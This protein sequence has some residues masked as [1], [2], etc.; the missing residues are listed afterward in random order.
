MRGEI[1]FALGIFLILPLFYL[2]VVMLVQKVFPAW[3]AFLASKTMTRFTL[4]KLIS[5]AMMAASFVMGFIWREH[6][7]LVDLCIASF[8][9]GLLTLKGKVDR[10]FEK[11]A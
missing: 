3:A 1:V 2:G 7:A 10:F 8:I 5:V 4:L 6:V 11:K 9:I